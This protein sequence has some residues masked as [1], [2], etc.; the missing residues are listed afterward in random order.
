MPIPFQY[1]PSYPNGTCPFGHGYLVRQWKGTYK[2][3]QWRCRQCAEKGNKFIYTTSEL[4]GRSKEVKE[5]LITR[6]YNNT[7]MDIKFVM[8]RS[9][10]YFKENIKP[11]VDFIKVA[12]PATARE[13]VPQSYKWSV[14][15]NYWTALEQVFVANG[16]TIREVSIDTSN[17]IPDI[18]VPK[19]YAENFHYKQEVVTTVESATSIADKL[20]A[21]LGV[22]ITT[23]ELNELKKLYRAKALEFHP[24]RGGDAAKMSELNRLWTLYCNTGVRQ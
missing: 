16:F 22:K 10:E 23:Q 4:S 3:E 12:I 1:N 17:E 2:L 13:Y 6:T 21:F 20:S 9:K 11:M 15:M 24:D 14:D 19:E 18:N 8:G 7:I 5:I